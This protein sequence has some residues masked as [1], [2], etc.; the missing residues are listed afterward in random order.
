MGY[1]ADHDV[2]WFEVAVGDAHVMQAVDGGGDL[3]DDG[4][5]L[6]LRE[7]FFF[8]AL[9]ECASIHVFEDD[10]EMCFVVEASVHLEDVAMLDAA[11][12]PDL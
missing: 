8:G 3:A 4:G 2:L 10:V 11:L 6:L 1:T 5:C 9:V 7:A 12:D